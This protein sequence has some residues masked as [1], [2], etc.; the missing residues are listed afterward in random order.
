LES[1]WKCANGL[2]I[3]A[4][5][6]DI[7]LVKIKLSVIP[8]LKSNCWLSVFCPYSLY[9]QTRYNAKIWLDRW[10]RFNEVILYTN[11]IFEEIQ[12]SWWYWNGNIGIDSRYRK[13][14]CTFS[15]W[16]QNHLFWISSKIQF[17]YSITS[18]NRHHL[19]SQILAL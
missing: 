7:S 18:L 5:Y 14:I 8:N 15:T 10:W 1:H 19:S 16:F 12:F 13:T 3:A 17:V 4:I 2:S 6:T 9:R 11:W